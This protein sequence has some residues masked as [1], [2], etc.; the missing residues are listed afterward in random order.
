MNKH[1]EELMLIVAYLVVMLTF[2][3]AVCQLHDLT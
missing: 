2:L 3:V 1:A